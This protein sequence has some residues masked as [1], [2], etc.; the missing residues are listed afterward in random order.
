M[1]SIYEAIK[2]AVQVFFPESEVTL[3]EA[4]KIG[5]TAPGLVVRQPNSNVAPF[6]SL[7]RYADADEI[8]VEDIAEQI[9]EIIISNSASENAR[10]LQTEAG[11][12]L[13]GWRDLIQVQL[14]RPQGNEAYLEDKVWRQFLD[15]GKIY[16]IQVM[17]EDD[18]N[19]TFVVKKDMLPSMGADED[20]IDSVAMTNTRNKN[21]PRFKNII[22]VLMEMMGESFPG[23]A[24]QEDDNGLPMYVLSN[25]SGIRG[26]VFLL[27]NDV[28][29]DCLKQMGEEDVVIL[30]SSVHEVLLVPASFARERGMDALV[31]MVSEVNNTQVPPEDLLSYSVYYYRLGG[32]LKILEPS[33]IGWVDIA[34][35]CNFE[36]AEGNDDVGIA[37]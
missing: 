13:E 22:Q 21:I 5:K 11:R 23:L 3:V 32:Q 6:V 9:R 31:N 35:A 18:T 4:Q 8:E 37:Q 17:T 14:M 12:A 27:F 1:K 36:P 19:A 25:Q 7:D 29:D 34:K 33:D 20:E 30:P 24:P 26:S 28:L 2:D 10:R 15:M 16:R